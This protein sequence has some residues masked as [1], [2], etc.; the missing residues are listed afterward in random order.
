[1]T[2]P[3][4]FTWTV[5]FSG[6]FPQVNGALR[7]ANPPTIGSS[8]PDSA[9]EWTVTGWIPIT[10]SG[11]LNFLAQLN[12]EVTPVPE[13]CTLLLLASGL[14]GLGGIAWTRNRK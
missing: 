14:A 10:D 9:W 4:T 12:A 11:S 7:A 5:E 13:P 6:A 3:D 1:M 8:D 2:V